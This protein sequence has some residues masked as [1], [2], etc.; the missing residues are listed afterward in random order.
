MPVKFLRQHDQYGDFWT[1]RVEGPYGGVYDVNPYVQLECAIEHQAKRGK[2][3]FKVRFTSGKNSK[4]I[5]TRTLGE[6]YDFI[7]EIRNELDHNWFWKQGGNSDD[8]TDDAMSQASER[9]P[10]S[11]KSNS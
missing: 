2:Y 3:G 9:K 11:I 10:P 8:D 5:Q 6:S 4:F 7:R 1:A